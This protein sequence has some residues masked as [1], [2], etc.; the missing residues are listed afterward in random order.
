MNRNTDLLLEK[1]LVL[2]ETEMRNQIRKLECDHCFYIF[3]AAKQRQSPPVMQS[4]NYQTN[5]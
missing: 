2:S 4:D 5:Y 1:Q 3:S